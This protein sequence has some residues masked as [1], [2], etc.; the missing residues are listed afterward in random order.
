MISVE[1]ES[2]LPRLDRM[3]FSSP[4]NRVSRE[5]ELSIKQNFASGGRPSTWAP[6]KRGG[7]SHLYKTG[8]LFSSIRHSNT[9]SV[10]RA[11]IP[12]E[13][14]PPY[15]RIH[16]FGFEGFMSNG[17]YMVMPR[18]Q[19]I[20]FQVQDIQNIKKILLGHITHFFN[21]GATE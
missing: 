7:P 6:K 13:G 19:Y 2:K 17:R 18:R 8:R 3:T 15:A 9:D 21:T 20:L 10:A 14:M 16:Q 12:V 4:L 5:L 1:I 11:G